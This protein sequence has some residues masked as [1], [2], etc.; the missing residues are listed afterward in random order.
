VR[1]C[2][3]AIVDLVVSRDGDAIHRSHRVFDDD[4]RA[5]LIS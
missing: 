5:S 1:L 2:C 4:M 3:K